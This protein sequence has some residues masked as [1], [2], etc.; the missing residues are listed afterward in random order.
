[1]N[2]CIPKVSPNG[3]VGAEW[4]FAFRKYHRM[5]YWER[6]RNVIWT[7]HGQLLWPKHSATMLLQQPCRDTITTR[8]P[9]CC[10]ASRSCSSVCTPWISHSANHT[11]ERGLRRGS[12]AAHAQWDA[13][14]PNLHHHLQQ[15][16]QAQ[17]GGD[18]RGDGDNSNDSTATAGFNWR[19]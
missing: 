8:D 4:T 11:K 6:N 9:I 1:M 19:Y 5:A 17:R 16:L 2:V 3:I 15:Q 18:I 10:N 7:K 12:D 13:H 14:H